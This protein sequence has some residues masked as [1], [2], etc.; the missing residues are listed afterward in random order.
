MGDRALVVV[1][2]DTG[3]EVGGDVGSAEDGDGL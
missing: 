2:R 1:E 3:G